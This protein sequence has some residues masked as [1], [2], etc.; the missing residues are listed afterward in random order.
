M[1]NHRTSH[2]ISILLASCRP[3][4]HGRP[5][6]QFAARMGAAERTCMQPAGAA[7]P[8]SYDAKPRSSLPASRNAEASFHSE[9]RCGRVFLSEPQRE[10]Q[11]TAPRQPRRRGGLPRQAAVWTGSSP[12]SRS[13]KIKVA[14]PGELRYGGGFPSERAQP[15]RSPCL[16]VVP[17]AGS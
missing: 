4:R 6:R 15:R 5:P 14:A 13:A 11:V 17:A 12:A 8:A 1:Y 2:L 10:G 7:S 9:R 16:A 3:R